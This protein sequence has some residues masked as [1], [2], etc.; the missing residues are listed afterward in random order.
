[1]CSFL[2]IKRRKSF[3][4]GSQNKKIDFMW[5]VSETTKGEALDVQMI[6]EALSCSTIYR[7]LQDRV[8]STLKKLLEIKN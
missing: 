4:T 8:I 6:R 1:M 7:E 3:F 5:E 2:V